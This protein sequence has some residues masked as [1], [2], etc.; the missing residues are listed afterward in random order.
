V[1]FR[2]KPH[3]DPGV[4]DAQGAAQPGARTLFL[5]PIQ[6][7]REAIHAVPAVKYALG[8][9]GVAAAAAVIG[10]LGLGLWNALAGALVVFVLMVILVIFARLTKAGT[11][12]FVLP[13]LVLMW[14]SL[15]LTIGSAC[16]LFTSLFFQWPLSFRGVLIVSSHSGGPAAQPSEDVRRFLSAARIQLDARDYEAAWKTLEQAVAMAPRAKEAADAQVQLAMAWLR[17]MQVSQPHTFTEVVDPLLA[18]LSQAAPAAQGPEA[19]DMFAHIGWGSFLKS[20]DGARLDPTVHYTHALELDPS[21]PFAHAMY[22]HWIL[23]RHGSLEDARSH[24]KK[25]LAADRER[26]FVRDLQLSAFRN[27]SSDPDVTLERIR[28]LDE[29]RR[30]HE[31]LSPAARSNLVSDIYFMSR[32]DVTAHLSDV[33]PAPDHLATFLWLIDGLDSSPLVQFWRA[34]LTELAGD[35]PGA[36]AYYKAMPDGTTY[37]EEIKKG[38]ARCEGKTGGR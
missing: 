23:W 22:G 29:M 13:M 27:N 12:R 37:D 33:L 28:T 30:R 35:Y 19:A 21:N 18:V 31:T 36:L 17:D 20:R 8:V 1:A 11:G 34:R 16:L 4:T 32:D 7:L 3:A 6:L 25:A 2:R 10:G 5:S 9:A 24:F 14:A 26:S 15:V 38:I